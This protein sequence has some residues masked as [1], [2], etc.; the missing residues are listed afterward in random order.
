MSRLV[1]L[2][3]ARRRHA[4]AFN[5]KMVLAAIKGELTLVQPGVHFDRTPTRI[6]RNPIF[7][8][9]LPMYLVLAVAT[10]RA[11]PRWT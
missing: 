2:R 3:Q 6:T 7:R 5:D 1:S 10:Q 4:P 8:K 9:R 11:S